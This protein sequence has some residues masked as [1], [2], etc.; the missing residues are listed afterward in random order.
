MSL[1]VLKSRTFARWA[2]KEGL[3]DAALCQSAHEV[4]RGLIDARLRGSLLKKRIGRRRGGKRDGFRT[5]IAYR[6]GERLF[7]IYGFAKSE[8]GNI[9]QTERAALMA[10]GEQYTGF[11]DPA[12]ERAIAAGALLEIACD[13]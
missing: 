9:T 10:L 7:F 13:G 5:I 6:E 11:D 3:S 1:R 2:E 12:L 4:R 8:R